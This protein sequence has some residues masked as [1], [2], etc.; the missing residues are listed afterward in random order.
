MPFVR[1]GILHSRSGTMAISEA[2]LVEAELMAIA[3]INHKGGILGQLIKPV[4]KDGESN[5]AKFE[6]KARKLIEL[7]QVST[8]FGCWSSICRK[9]VLPVLEEFNALLWYPVKYEGL[10]C[11]KNIFYIGSVPNQQI[12]PAI[13]WLLSNKRQQFYLLGSD[14]VFSRTA[15]KIVKAQLKHQGGT[16]VGEKYVPLGTKNFTDLM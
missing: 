11:S 14:E 13:T 10:E 16:I 6:R 15:N 7:G 2:P 9:A 5:P 1:V 4:I 8:L 12:E 3:E